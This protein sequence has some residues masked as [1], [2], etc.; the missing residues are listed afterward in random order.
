MGN[1]TVRTDRKREVFL[2]TLTQAGNVSQACRTAGIGYTTVYK[3]REE[4]SDFA[5]AWE[6]ALKQAVD[7]LEGEAWRRA[8]EGV[9][10]PVYQQGVMVGTVTEHSDRL[11]EVLLKAHGGEKYRDRVKADV[12]G[13]VTIKIAGDAADL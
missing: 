3:W 11:M 4:D 5:A 1:R 10:K 9:E 8:V 2:A 12:S 6:V 7:R 13:N